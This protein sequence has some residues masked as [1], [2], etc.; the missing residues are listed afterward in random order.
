[1]AVRAAVALV[2]VLAIA[3]AGSR[4]AYPATTGLV[5]AYA[6]SE[7]SGST[8]A[9]LSGNGNNGTIV[10][11][12]WTTGGKFGNA[13]NF[14]GSSTHVDIP[15]SPTLRL[16]GAMTLE[17]WVKPAAAS[18]VWK[19]VVYKGNDNYYLEASTTNGGLPAGGGTFGGSNANVYQP[20]T[21]STGVWSHIAVTY[22]GAA[23]RYYISG[24]LV[25]TQA[26]TGAITGSANPLQIGGDNFWSKQFFNG[27]I[28]EV[29]VYNIALAASAIQAD[30]TTA[31]DT[32][33]GS[34]DTTP[35]GAPGTL[36]ATA[37][38]SNAINLTWGA[39][40]DNV[41]V[42]GY[43]IERC[44]GTG[45]SSFA[46]IGTSSTT[47]FGDTGLA[48]STSYSYRVRANDTATNLGPYS[49]TA[50]ASTGAS[51]SGLVAA[52]AFSEGTGTSVADLSGHGNG[53]TLV[54]ATW[55]TAGKY[56]KALAFNGTNA[57]V[58]IPDSASLHLTSGMTLE[59]WVNPSVAPSGWKDVIYKGNDNYYLEASGGSKPAGGGTFGGSNSNVFAPSALAVGSWTHIAV[60][61]D[62]AALRY[63]VNGSLV[64]TQP[65]TGAIT[66]STNPLQIGGDSF[67]GSQYFKGSIDEVRV[68]NGVLSAAAI[69]A[70]MAAPIDAGAPDTQPPSAP[71]A[72]SAT[73]GGPNALNL[74][75]ATATD[76]VAIGSYRVERCQG[77]TCSTFTQI[78]T[79]STTTFNDTGLTAST[80]YSYQVRA[81]DTSQNVGPY[82]NVAIATTGEEGQANL[83]A[84]YGFSEGSGTTVADFSG[85][86]N[87]GT[88]IGVT[89]TPDGKYGNAL[90]FNGTSSRVDIPDSASLH[91]TSGMTL[92][93]WV[94]PTSS[95][96]GWKDV[97]YK[98]NDNYYLESSTNRMAPA[99]G[100]TFG[101]SNANTY[102]T[103]AVTA[104]VWTHLAVT[105]DG[106]T[107]RLYVNGS[108][109]GSQAKTGL[110]T[111]STNMLQIGGDSIFG[112]YFQG[113][114][115]EIRV[116]DGA[117]AQADIAADMATP[118]DTSGT[119]DTQPPSATGPM[120]AMANG[121]NEI[122][123]AWGAATDNVAVTGYR[124][125]RCQGAGCT[126]FSHLV[127]IQPPVLNYSDVG[128][129]AGTTYRYQV[130]AM[131]G[132]GNLG[133]VSAP[134]TAT[135]GAPVNANLVAAYGFEE[136]SGN[137]VVDSSGHGNNGTLVNAT[138]TTSGKFGR[139]LVFN[140]TNAR[141][142]IA[143]SASLHVTA[144]MTLEAW[145]APTTSPTGWKDAIYKGDE[146][147]YLGAS[148]GGNLGAPAGGG[149]IG[150]TGTTVVG[151]T[152]L[153]SSTWSHLAL[154]YDGSTLRLY[155]NGSQV[156]TKAKT[157]AIT[158]STN[159]LQIG[160]DTFFSDQY[161]NGMIDEVRVYD[162][163]LT[164]AQIQA[165]MNAGVT[166]PTAP[167]SLTVTVP[168]TSEVD[169]SWG[170]STATSGITGYRVERCQ[171]V[172]CSNFAQIAA[173]TGLSYPDTGLTAST[174]Y[175]YRV[176]AVDSQGHLSPYSDLVSAFT[177]LVVSP[178]QAALTP[179]QTQ[180]YTA[181]SPGGGLPTVTWSVDGVAGGTTASG[182]IT[183]G[184]IYT[185]PAAAGTH[186]VSAAVQGGSNTGS[187]S[188]FVTNYAGIFTF[189]N[190]NMR[191]GQNS[192]ET[193][194]TTSNVNSAS[195][196]KLFTRP[197]DGLTYASPLYV[198]N[199]SVPA[200]GSKNLVYIATE[201]DSVYAYDADGKS[202]TPV[203]KDSFI[204]P[205][206][207]VTTVPAADTG[208]CCDIPNEIGIT[209]T[210]VIDK[211]TNTLYVV[212]KTK[213]VSGGTTTY[214][215]RL[216]ALDLATGAERFGGP[217][218]I[219]ATVPGT[220]A[221]SVGGQLAFNSLRENQ[222]TALLLLNGTLYFGFSSHGDN[223]PY[224]GWIFGYNA[225]NLQRTLAL[226]ITPNDEGAGV[227]M[228]GGALASDA[229][230]S[231]FYVSGDGEFTGNTGGS[232]WGDSY[233]KMSQA[234]TITDYFTPFNQA[235][236]NAAN[237]DL[238]SGGL[239]LIPDQ[240]GAH[241][242]EM[243]SSGKDGA[244]Y[245][246]DRDSL[247]HYNG[248]SNTNIQTLQNIFPNGSPEPGNFSSPVYFNGY[249]FFGPTGDSIQAFKLTNGLLPTSATLRST[250]VFPVRGTPMTVSSN[251][252]SNG[253]LWAVQPS[254]SSA[255]G[256]LRAYDPT[257]SMNGVLKEIYDSD[258]AGSRD[259]LD[260]G[261][262]FSIPVVANGKVF[263][264][265]SSQLTV[266]GL[267]P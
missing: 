92:E 168:S 14:N 39:A 235:A 82:S 99:G 212:A 22:D 191:T 206:N 246:V 255:P 60:T 9:D 198:E 258:Q 164:T 67:F 75:W 135:T 11:A 55:A 217:V 66:T 19:D 129:T 49:N 125:D 80:S 181:T 98:G 111:T 5:A 232:S 18:T 225:S 149:T 48:S 197:T 267:L 216:H 203:W 13:L 205:A 50:N 251:G 83:V 28:D 4:G 74:S 228:S 114:I 33:G 15:D 139:A 141:V 107:L 46:E 133:P 142:D 170:A 182:T 59:A 127:Q 42:T 16:S 179:G 31:I 245:L 52:Y 84:A 192:S 252:A 151:M 136:T 166:I 160:G 248:T 173:P 77:V 219:Q 262:K 194:L 89:W 3:S 221:G 146:N 76:N 263:V 260:P 51:T 204:N 2:A 1:L 176:R 147:F 193:V 38:G 106:A 201:H 174:S 187:G 94:D 138:R 88:I 71:G 56:G 117:I 17:A 32:S 43:R 253:I 233:L 41:G 162:G 70:D 103:A 200:Q 24:T 93:A 229:S 184:G 144:A 208:E 167:S 220:G 53:G 97:V 236:L 79:T 118:I 261:A 6:F 10:G 165:D 140:G 68:Y 186:T 26:K 153:A 123:L 61:Y 237:H 188:V 249:V 214:V 250:A 96:N 131:D 110:L 177:G 126:N 226:C 25:A 223:Q 210:P 27:T 12:A 159:P 189:H 62:G 199:V 64:A 101:G 119:T 150:G 218:V 120:T 109:A 211:T 215:Q 152:A 36:I 44:Q 180:A 134:A 158:T 54:N 257:G 183:A 63:Y 45:C 230:G 185:A 47:S 207:G 154:T 244:I 23:L 238:G 81:V 35:P 7:N 213:E 222:R 30:M 105:Y 102:G 171:G 108:L 234:G 157:G 124:V 113:T 227:W 231:I 21:L 73:A 87:S 163:A 86:G 242:H 58:D 161:F 209:S 172:G 266:Y 104:N 40:T 57:R 143:D 116:Y 115:D 95:P 155:V 91:L 224:H 196:G 156:A 69:Q 241:P 132:A 137:T 264:I 259:T 148:S 254:G 247:G 239:L 90:T 178:R 130:R 65:K 202:T 175:T 112:Q 100:G 190:D 34:G 20:T 121:S 195:F 243:I 78:G 85:N 128:L 256:T 240:P 145:V 122:D 8:L 265:G 29:R 37:A 72:L 169:L